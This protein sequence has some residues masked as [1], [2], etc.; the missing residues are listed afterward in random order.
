VTQQRRRIDIV[1]A[2]DYLDGL[3]E[4]SD[5]DLQGMHDECQELETEVSYV[6]RL[7]QARI[8]IL[9]A[10]RDRRA[11]GGS[12]ADLI[13]ALPK[14]LADPGPRPDPASS[15][16]S[17]HLAPAPAIQWT[18]GREPLIVDDTLANLPTLSDETL[19]STLSELG[20]L[21]RDVSERRRDLHGVIDVI[22]TELARR[23][24]TA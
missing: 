18:R 16:L 20:E 1:L 12:L 9:N 13:A 3:D 8:E 15:R 11:T 19:E 17:R 21:E 6:R 10:E 7:A 22:E 5:D 4:R 23:R 2:S 14:I 24:V